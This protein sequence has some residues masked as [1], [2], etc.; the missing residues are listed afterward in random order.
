MDR[1]QRLNVEY[2][3]LRTDLLDE[4]NLVDERMIKPAVDAKEYLQPFKKI[5]KKRDDKKVRDKILHTTYCFEKPK[6]LLPEMCHHNGFILPTGPFNEM[7]LKSI[8]TNHKELRL[9]GPLLTRYL[10]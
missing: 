8:N 5:I 1:T 6:T 10:V 3:E 2:G 9:H 7:N 4:V